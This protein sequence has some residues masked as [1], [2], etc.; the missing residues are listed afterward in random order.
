MNRIQS[1]AFIKLQKNRNRNW[2]WKQYRASSAAASNGLLERLRQQNENDI[3]ALPEFKARMTLSEFLASGG[4]TSNSI[5]PVCPPPTGY[6]HILSPTQMRI[7]LDAA[8]ATFHLHVESRIAAL[9]GQGYYTI[10]PCGEEILAS[11]GWALDP[12]TDAVALHY[13]HLSVS[14]LRQL[15]LG[16][17]LEDIILDRARGHVVSKLDPVTGGVGNTFIFEILPMLQLIIL[18]SCSDNYSHRMLGALC[19]RLCETPHR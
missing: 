4:T 7:T 10:G 17:N 13:R 2:I 5:V 18:R 8:M 16:R 19:H 14:I 1:T 3:I 12:Y 9:C 6:K 11:I 15:R